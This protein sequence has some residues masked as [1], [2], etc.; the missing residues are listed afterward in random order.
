MSGMGLMLVALLG[1]PKS[2]STLEGAL[3]DEASETSSATDPLTVLTES[4]TSEDPSPRARALALLLEQEGPGRWGQ[5]ALA[6]ESD[7]VRRAAIEALARRSDPDS[8][9]LLE[10]L[11]ADPQVDPYL[12]G[13]AALRAPGPAS[14]EAIRAALEQEREA[15]R[16]A[17]LA[18]AAVRLGDE[19]AR[20][21]LVR[22]LE[23][24]ELPL[25]IEFMHEIGQTGDASLVPALV[26]AQERVEEELVL[27]IA[28]ARLMLGDAAGE[29]A[30]R[31]AL[32]EDDEERRLEA[33]DYLVELDHPA[34]TTL[35]RRASSL[36]PDLV[37]WYADLALAARTD[38]NGQ[39]FEKAFAEPDRELRSLAVRFAGE[40][41]GAPSK[42]AEKGAQKVLTQ[43]LSDPDAWVR[44]GAC[45]AAA[46]LGMTD[47]RTAMEALLGDEVELVRV[48]AS[49]AL[50]A[51]AGG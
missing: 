10:G 21:R 18:L 19:A 12:R 4:A 50:L 14:A 5:Q 1:C 24:G 40:A 11:V 37:T 38:T 25:E 3:P 47:T 41:L 42:R 45:R 27:P 43:A 44:A 49:G 15:W 2:G 26:H 20:A 8:R 7:W 16:V 34:A 30:L 17:P 29:Q 22:A 31:T 39:V 32:S 46:E 48:E 28:S 6:D 13:L 35:L 36:G 23:S 51:M 33:L 9:A